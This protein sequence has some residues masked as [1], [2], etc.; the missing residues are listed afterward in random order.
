M[1]NP[2]KIYLI[3]V[4]YNAMKWAEKCFCSVRKSSVPV[5]C[6]VIDNGSRDGTQDF[7]KTNFPEVELI[8]SSSNLGF[9]KANNIGIEKAYKN[10]ADF[11]YLMNQ[12]AWIYEDSI[13]KLLDVYNSYPQKNEIG[14]ITPM[15]LDGS[16]KKLDI[17]FERYLARNSYMNRFLSDYVLGKTNQHYSVDFIN[18]AHWFLPKKTVNVV[19]GFNPYFFH[20]SEDNEYVQR[21]TYFKKKIL[22]ATK[23]F[24]VHD[25]KQDFGKTKHINAKRVQREQRYLDPAQHFSKSMFK[26]EFRTNILKLILKCHFS[27]ASVL[28]NEYMYQSSRVQEIMESRKKT[29][30]PQPSFLKL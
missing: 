10:G 22:V 15:H 4:T 17:F 27:Q 18:A 3:I 2:I 19:G 30:L 28:Y 16:E 12:D 8:Q 14:I 1:E 26:R 29:S 6:I 20:Y 21:V 13:Q 25:G 5:S 24:V 9:G 7:I 11:F 23:S